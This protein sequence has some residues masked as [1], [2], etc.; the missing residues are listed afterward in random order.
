MP[1][2]P[3]AT[4]ACVFCEIASRRDDRPLLY[5]DDECVVFEPLG[6]IVPGHV[7]VV[8][9]AHQDSAADS[10]V[11][12]AVTFRTAARYAR[13]HYEAFNLITS[14]GSDAT[15]TIMHLHVHIVPRQRGDGLLLPWS[16]QDPTERTP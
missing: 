14:S 8:P 5:A 10:L 2:T 12:T 4:A 3:P 16:N 11:G 15:Q 9:T 13:E 6:P 7:L 1:D